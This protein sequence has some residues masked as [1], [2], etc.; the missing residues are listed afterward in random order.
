MYSIV[1]RDFMLYIL[2]IFI[3]IISLGLS[4]TMDKHIVNLIHRKIEY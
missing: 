4:Q 3:S 2:K 1:H